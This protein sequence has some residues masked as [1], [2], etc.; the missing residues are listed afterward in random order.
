MVGLL[1][2]LA[3]CAVLVMAVAASGPSA[4]SAEVSN[5][6][7]SEVYVADVREA[8]PELRLSSS[9]ELRPDGR[10]DWRMQMGQLT[11]SASGEWERDGPMI[12]LHNPDQ[13][14]EPAL[15]LASAT[16]DPADLL[17]VSLEPATARMASVLELEL[18]YP[19]NSFMRVPLGDGAISIP[20]GQERPIA[21]RL[22]SEPFTIR[23]QPIAIAPDGPNVLTLRLVPADLGQAFFGSQQSAFDERGMTID[24]RGIAIRYDR[25]PSG[26][27]G[28]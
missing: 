24:F 2:N 26:P 17:R 23:T 9:I 7:G 18:E 11:L 4:R 20:A 28:N 13:V 5:A 27:R 10:F 3:G 21:V 22:M 8:P 16:R 15:E 6:G 19:G 12:R 25:G 14:G 1:H